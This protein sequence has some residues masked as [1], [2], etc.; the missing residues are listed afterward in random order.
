M[1]IAEVISGLREK[2]D[3]RFQNDQFKFRK[4][5]AEYVRKNG[6]LKYMF[7]LGV[8][9]KTGWFPVTPAAFVNSATV[10]KT[11]NEILGSNIPVT[12]GTCGFGVGNE[13]NHERGRYQ[14][15]M[16]TDIASTAEAIWRDYT[17]VASP[18]FATIDSLEAIDRYMNTICDDGTPTGSIS[19]ACLGLIVAKMVGNPRFFEIAE[20]YY[21]F[22]AEA[23]SPEIASDI[24]TVR[25][26][27]NRCG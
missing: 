12:G 20:T 11:F 9:A 18:F 2:L 19:D 17:E 21:E 23:Q 4:A 5:N 25:N 13:C 7:W 22:W 8:N 16:V 24:L 3:L 15:E 26:A 10:N 6:D 14:I 27:L 1:K